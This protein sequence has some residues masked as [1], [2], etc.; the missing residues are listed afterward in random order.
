MA[1]LRDGTQLKSGRIDLFFKKDVVIEVVEGCYHFGDG[2]SVPIAILGERS[3]WWQF[4]L[5][6][7]SVV[8]VL[9]GETSL[10]ILEDE[11]GSY[12]VFIPRELVEHVSLA[13]DLRLDE[14][15]LDDVIPEG[16]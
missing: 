14:V 3:G 11:V 1:F 4:T 12:R 8:G 7:S 5:P 9:L 6:N 10:V 2:I 16:S 15:K 13:T